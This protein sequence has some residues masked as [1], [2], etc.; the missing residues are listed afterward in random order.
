MVTSDNG[1]SPEGGDVG[2]LNENDFFN[3][4]PTDIKANL[5]ALDTLGSP[6][7]Y[8]HYV[9]GWANTGNTPYKRW[10]KETFRGGTTDPFV[11][12]GPAKIDAHGEF[13]S[14]Y[15]HA[16]DMVPTVLDLLDIDPPKSIKGVKQDPIEGLSLARSAKE[17]SA[18]DVHTLQYFEVLGSRSIYHGGWRAECG[19]PG[20][21]YKTGARHGHKVGDTIHAD[22][23]VELDKTWELYDVS[24]DPTECHDLAQKHPEK[25]KEMI[26]L[27]YEEA[28]KCNALPLQGTIGQRVGFPRPMPGRPTDMHSHQTRRGF[29]FDIPPYQHRS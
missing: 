21:N 10:K 27:W 18:P 29:F 3:F 12:S 9:W 23:L 22:D 2:T 25:L 7:H 1:A 26:N 19:W 24:K 5:A 6:E 8:N 15:G 16:V 13:R 11:V 20:P 4:M 14:Q 17:A 28:R